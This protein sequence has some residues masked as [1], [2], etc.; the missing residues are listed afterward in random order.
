MGICDLTSAVACLDNPDGADGAILCFDKTASNNGTD[1]G[2]ALAAGH[3]VT[4]QLTGV[5]SYPKADVDCSANSRHRK[6]Y[7]GRL[8]EIPIAVKGLA[9]PLK[10]ELTTAPAGA[11][12]GETLTVS[13]DKQ[14]V[15]ATYGIVSFT[16]ASDDTY[17]FTVKVTDQEG[18]T[19]TRSWSM[20]SN[21][22][23][24]DHVHISTAG[25]DANDGSA[26]SP[27]TIA[28]IT[29]NQ[30]GGK[31]AWFVAGT[32]TLPTTSTDN[33]S[34]DTTN[35]PQAFI[36]MPAASVTMA[37]TSAKLGVSNGANSSDLFIGDITLDGMSA[38][39]NKHILFNDSANKRFT[40]FRV[41][42]D[43]YASN[44]AA[45]N[46]GYIDA[47]SAIEDLCIIR[48]TFAGANQGATMTLYD[49]TNVVFE[50]AAWTGTVNDSTT[51]NNAVIYLKQQ[52][53]EQTFF[54]LDA[55][56]V[57]LSA[58]SSFFAFGNNNAPTKDVENIDVCYSKFRDTGTYHS[59]DMINANSGT[60]YGTNINF[61]R[62]NNEGNSINWTGTAP[63]SL[64]NIDNISTGTYQSGTGYTNTGNLESQTTPFD[65][66]MNLTGAIRTSNL[67]TEGAEIV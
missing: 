23:T 19:L 5:I 24:T 3:F 53:K 66:S 54:N 18:T 63:I 25:N 8:Y 49:A 64:A 22:T 12:I 2:W 60:P 58:Q 39:N 10:Y 29:N 50:H 45:T 55:S 51:G 14:I 42:H 33:F 28:D 30:H 43:N 35:H 59:R 36:P 34:W 61:Y 11:T 1:S 67:G 26:A 41:T 47:L 31:I 65:A 32:H 57:T 4:A 16:P 6:H 44:G 17:N 7:T 27:V 46:G 37:L 52:C 20:V 15:G 13:G 21:Q 56:A 40:S 9:R 38:G 48:P 62:N